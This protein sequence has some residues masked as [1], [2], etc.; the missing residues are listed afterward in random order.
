MW[1]CAT[2]PSALCKCLKDKGL[3]YYRVY[4][5]PAINTHNN[6]QKHNLDMI[7]GP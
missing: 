2:D 6:E 7:Q 3:V 4:Q 1:Q 5:I